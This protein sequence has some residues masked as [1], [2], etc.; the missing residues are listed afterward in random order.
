MT[1]TRFSG[2]WKEVAFGEIFEFLNTYA[3]SREQL[4]T[5]P[6]ESVEVYNIHYGDIH[7][8]YDG[9]VLDFE[10]EAAV[11][12]LKKATEIPSN[13]I[14]LQE[15]DLVI[16]DACFAGVMFNSRSVIKDSDKEIEEK[17]RTP[18]CKAM[19]SES[20]KEADDNS[21]FAKYLIEELYENDEIAITA[22]K[23][24]S[25]LYQPVKDNG[26]DPRYGTIKIGR[27]R[28]GEFIF[29]RKQN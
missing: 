17:F 18:S 25:K 29:F 14:F 16:A 22:V 19:T 20:F 21:A 12:L 8:T 15:G 23:L 13:P 6:Q 5:A 10:K 27:D 7:A 11:P 24:Y 4:T 1:W 3:F 28:G 9:Y 26:G 2:E